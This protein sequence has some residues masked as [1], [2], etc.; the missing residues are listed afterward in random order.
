MALYYNRLHYSGGFFKRFCVK[1][2]TEIQTNIHILS[3]TNGLNG[4]Y[5]WIESHQVVWQG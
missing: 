5:Y 3:L 2:F 4:H 1:A